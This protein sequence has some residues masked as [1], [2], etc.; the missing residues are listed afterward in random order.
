MA[1]RSGCATAVLWGLGL[2]V[3]IPGLCTLLLIDRTVSKDFA[4]YGPILLWVAIGIAICGTLYLI[5]DFSRG[6]SDPGN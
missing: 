3:A 4:A 1:E 6:P 2:I 5:Y